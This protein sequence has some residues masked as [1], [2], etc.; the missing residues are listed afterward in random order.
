M[1]TSL[2][3]I[4]NTKRLE[5]L[6]NFVNPGIIQINTGLP[7]LQGK[8]G[9]PG[10]PGPRGPRGRPAPP[11]SRTIYT[12]DTVNLASINHNLIIPVNASLIKLNSSSD[13]SVTGA[14]APSDHE[15]KLFINTSSYTISFVSNSGSSSAGNRFL[16]PTTIKIKQYEN[17]A[18]I[19]ESSIN[20]WLLLY[21]TSAPEEFDG[22]TSS[23]F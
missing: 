15:M 11:S 17:I 2:L 9:P 16:L 3:Y 23:S 13:C 7:G 21:T 10:P 22:G 1:A 12:A 14:I 6:D 5:V 18:L 8:D 20:G 19:Y 4:D